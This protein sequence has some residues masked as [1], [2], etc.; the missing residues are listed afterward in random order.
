[1]KARS[2]GILPLP[3]YDVVWGNFQS[4]PL[5]GSWSHSSR[6]T[7]PGEHQD[8]LLSASLHDAA[9]A[10]W[11]LQ[12]PL[13]SLVQ[14]WQFGEAARTT[15]GGEPGEWS[16]RASR[17]QWPTAA[18]KAAQSFQQLR[19]P[20]EVGANVALVNQCISIVIN[21]MGAPCIFLIG[22]VSQ[23][24]VLP[25]SSMLQAKRML[26]HLTYVWGQGITF[27]GI[28]SWR[29]DN[30]DLWYLHSTVL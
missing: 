17:W 11:K 7:D 2:L 25:A 22:L 1:M 6:H 8:A 15:P 14:T 28:M 21:D 10:M 20:A 18:Q 13:C 29:H 19:Q 5:L 4:P 26:Y 30:N 9:S 24:A 23:V 3:T 27:L 16:A 12:I